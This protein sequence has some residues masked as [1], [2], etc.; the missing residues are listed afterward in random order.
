MYKPIGP[1]IVSI[2]LPQ[3]LKIAKPIDISPNTT[4][5]AALMIELTQ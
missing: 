4:L 5:S 3:I 1:V 2:G